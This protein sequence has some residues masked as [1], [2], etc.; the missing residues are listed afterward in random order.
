L[1]DRVR[2][3]IDP[4]G[5]GVDALR[6][7]LGP[8]ASW[9]LAEI[10][11]KNGESASFEIALPEDYLG[12]P[13]TLQIGFP[14]EFP[15]SGLRVRI[16]PSPWLAWPHV[17]KG[18]VCLFGGRQRPA[19]GTPEEIV[20]ETWR[21][22][23][24]LMTWVVSGSNAAARQTEFDSE[25]TSYWNEQLTVSQQQLVLLDRPNEG[26][27]LFALTDTR[28]DRAAGV[29]IVWVASETNRL[30]R[31][32]ERMTGHRAPVKAPAA[33][34]FF[35]P[36]ATLPDVRLP[37]PNQLVDWLRP[38]L[39]PSVQPAFDEWAQTAQG[40]PL[41]WLVLQLPN[42]GPSTLYA[43]ALRSSGVR[44]DGSK[45][46]GRRAARRS[47]SHVATATIAR[48]DAAVVHAL[49]RATVHSRDL[50]A[51]KE[52][53]ASSHIA[54]VGLGTLGSALAVQLARVGVGKLTLIDPDLLSDA[55]LGRHVLGA[56]D[57]GRSKA[58]ALREKLRRDMPS[59]E[60]A[61]LPEYIQ[62][63]LTKHAD[64]FAS[65]DLVAITTAD[66]PSEI[67]VWQ[68][69]SR[70]AAWSLVQAWSEPFAVVGHALVAPAG[71]FDG[72]ALFH[73]H[74]QFRQRYSTWP[75]D[76]IQALP[77]CGANYIPGGPVALAAITA[78]IAEAV[79]Q[80]LTKPV[81]SPTWLTTVGNPQ[82]I[83]EAGGAYGG[84]DFPAGV[85]S[86]TFTRDWPA[87]NGGVEAA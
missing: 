65:V 24:Q 39:D 7:A 29:Q 67:A 36:L 6:A 9:L 46:Y 59:I 53:L 41:R 69:K 42:V 23:R 32:W 80:A 47:G 83:T 84:P 86:L 49:D 35:A 19:S 70:G 81:A 28:S 68:E 15:R 33:P 82:A 3:N 72:R 57:L 63:A 79:V 17:M 60:V 34:A 37:A 74:G 25:I 56:S 16:E 1:D 55:N 14:Q 20:G 21:R 50:T 85:S 54:L 18:G 40:Q 4:L 61:A 64:L 27:P 76:G 62:S 31:H 75:D 26:Q 51:T 44:R 30:S 71:A 5:R 52:A 78:M 66:W 43:L 87:T 45:T 13:R 48:V 12:V 58:I 8:D 22:I 11:P 73:A 77:G 10:E 38:H 2:S